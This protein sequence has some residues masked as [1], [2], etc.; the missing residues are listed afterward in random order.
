MKL[1]FYTVGHSDRS[2]AEFTGLLTAVDIGLLADIRKLPG[3][4]AHPQFNE[5]V[6]AG[7]LADLDIAYEHVAA[8]GGLRGKSADVPKELNGLWRNASFHRY[9]D[10]ALSPPFRDGLA[11]VVDQ[12]RERRCALMC[13]EAVWWRCHR[14]IVADYLLAAG[15]TVF[16]LMGK[17]R[18]EPARLTPGAVVRSD[19]TLVYP[20]EPQTDA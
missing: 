3:S 18:L 17:G 12:A 9:A 10:Y 13:S 2:L 5:D 14:R 19:G 4:R 6:L 8:L 15:E 16:H 11:Q 1:P 7:S 20:A